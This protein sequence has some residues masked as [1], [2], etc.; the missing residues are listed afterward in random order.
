M[1]IS[2]AIGSW[3]IGIGLFRPTL[4]ELKAACKIDQTVPVVAGLPYLLSAG[5]NFLITLSF[6]ANRQPDP[7]VQKIS[8]P[9]VADFLSERPE[10]VL[11]EVGGIEIF[12]IQATGSAEEF[13]E[14]IEKVV[15]ARFN[16]VSE[17]DRWT[18]IYGESLSFH[19][20][21]LPQT[22]VS[23]SQSRMDEICFNF[24]PKYSGSHQPILRRHPTR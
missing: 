18:I 1:D 7:S 10:I 13:L 19:F 11:D 5:S 17:S 16:L 6:L 14:R 21:P 2:R 8:I 4:S 3:N 20:S 23:P 15:A 12:G 24:G 22:E 9:L